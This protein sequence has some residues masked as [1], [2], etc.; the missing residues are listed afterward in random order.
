MPARLLEKPRNSSDRI[1]PELPRAPR[2][3][4]EDAV[5][6]VWLTVGFCSRS[7]SRAAA[8]RVM[9][10][11]VPVSPSGTGNTL[12]SS[13]DCLTCAKCRDADTMASRN[14]LP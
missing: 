12:S 14:T 7:S 3:N 1:T 13:T 2:N 11:L 10:I 5:S 8:D 4:A 6:A 9:D